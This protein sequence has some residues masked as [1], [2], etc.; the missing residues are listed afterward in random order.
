MTGMSIS[1]AHR[2]LILETSGRVGAVALAEGARLLSSRRLDEARRHT[3]DLAPA[4]ADLLT[5]QG[6]KPRDVAAVFVS[7]G[8][9]SYTGLRVGIMSAKTFAYATGC[10]VAA[11]DT[12]AAIAGQAPTEFNRL[13]VIVDAQQDKLYVQPF[14]KVHATWTNERPVAI[15]PFSEWLV[16]RDSSVPVTGP[17][18]RA[19]GDRLPHDTPTAPS[20]AWDPRVDSLLKLGVTRFNAE[21]RDDLWSLEPVYLRPSSAEEKLRTP[22]CS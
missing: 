15:V 16:S 19:C 17:G 1:Q 14:R 12:L 22:K 21:E 20:D 9:G 11:I 3:R 13:D 6:W 18:L 7:H 4:I 5:A 8:P 2:F 10:A